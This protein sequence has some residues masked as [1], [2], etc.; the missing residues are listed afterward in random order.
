[1]YMTTEQSNKFDFH[2]LTHTESDKELCNE[3]SIRLVLFL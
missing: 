3:L 1:M 2:V